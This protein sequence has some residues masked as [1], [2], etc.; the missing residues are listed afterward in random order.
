[1]IAGM[2]ALAKQRPELVQRMITD[3][4][5]GTVTVELHTNKN[6][7]FAWPDTDGASVHRIR[8]TKELPTIN[9]KTP[10]YA[11]GADGQLWPGLV[12]KAYAIHMAESNY[13]GL[14]TGG[15]VGRAMEVLAGGRSK[16][17]ATQYEDSDVLLSRLDAS[18]QEK[19]PLAAG[20]MDK[21]ALKTD[22]ELKALADEKTVYPWH[23]YVITDVDVKN[24]E[25]RL[26]NPW[27]SRHPKPMTIQ[28]FQRLYRTVYVG[29]PESAPVTMPAPDTD[30]VG[31]RGADLNRGS[32]HGTT[33]RA[34]VA[35]TRVDY[36]G[37]VAQSQL[38]GE[39][40]KK[41]ISGIDG[42]LINE[43]SWVTHGHHSLDEEVAATFSGGRYARMILNRPL[44]L[45]R[46]WHPE[47][48]R[49][50]GGF[51]SMEKPRGS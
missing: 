18:L 42:E 4:G 9:G 19:K 36:E 49:E 39:G 27:G 24:N 31:T 46:A 2:G 13:Q 41:I 35:N 37:G 10:T 15:S 1:L 25:V 3:H 28:E 20:S 45:Y 47:T 7:Y 21:D 16:A 50:F 40:Y 26:Y 32:S 29:N 38:A 14:N 8:I 6:G 48:S 12:E 33:Q 51:W 22:A 44:T 11:K 23:A 17:I 34:D 30:H 5:D 43:H